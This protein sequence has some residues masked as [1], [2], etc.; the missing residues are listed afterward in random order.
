MKLAMRW[1]LGAVAV[2]SVGCSMDMS[3]HD[4]PPTIQPDS[5]ATQP[6]NIA[7]ITVDT[8]QRYQTLVGFG[9]ALA[10]YA[11]NLAAFP[12]GSP[13][14][15]DV[16]KNLGLDI[17]RFRNHYQRTD[18]TYS[19]TLTDE[20]TVISRL[21]ASLGHA[22]KI[23]LSSWSPP[24]SLKASGKENCT[25]ST[26]PGCTLAKDGN[27]FVYDKFAQYFVDSLG[28]YAASNIHPDYLSIQNEPNYS[29]SWEGCFFDS[30]ESTQYP[31]YE[32][33]LRAVRTA[34]KSV[35]G[36]PKLL[37]P[38]VINLDN[39][40]FNSYVTDSS[41]SLYDVLAHHLYN[42][43]TW[44]NPDGLLG[45]YQS[46]LN[47]AKGLPIF[48]TEFDTQDDKGTGGFGAAW[49][50][51]NTLAVENVSAFLYWG[52][53]WGGRAGDEPSNAMVWLTSD[54]TTNQSGYLLRPQYYAMRHYARFT[55]PGYVRVAAVSKFD[56]VRVSAYVAPNGEQLTMVLL[57][58]SGNEKT[59]VFDSISGFAVQ[60]TRAFQ[61]KFDP[62]GDRAQ[63]EF[64]K[65]LTN[66]DTSQHFTLP[67]KSVLTV[68]LNKNAVVAT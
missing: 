3:R 4:I 60:R 11:S 32:K 27:G 44:Q 8:G 33:A 54:A 38:E 35:S 49:A 13:I 51:H 7:H 58:V 55:D 36:A 18:N 12:D 45:Q 14:F 65:E 28:W 63:S 6:D 10:W 16:A 1:C 48:Q 57:N 42:K 19:D 29:P 53:L 50:M 17:V 59:A 24:G 9:A 41:R 62:N 22:P 34:L 23:L 25:G 61:S 39:S 37:G 21:T 26:D 66:F 31:S 20:S 30:A 15:D 67:P 40:A 52:L 56:D 47:D 2:L 46:V 5:G 68:V 43:A 64:W